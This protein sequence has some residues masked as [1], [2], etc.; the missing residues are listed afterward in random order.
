MPVIPMPVDNPPITDINI[1][2]F[3]PKVNLAP[4]D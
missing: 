3:I 2:D 4:S 1:G